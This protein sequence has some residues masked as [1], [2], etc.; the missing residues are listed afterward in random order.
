MGPG[1]TTKTAQEWIEKHDKELSVQPGLHVFQVLNL[2]Q[3]LWERL[4]EIQSLQVYSCH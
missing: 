1:I 3:H 4:E 2:I